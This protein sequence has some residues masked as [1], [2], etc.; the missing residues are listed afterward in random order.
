MQTPALERPATETTVQI[1]A[2]GGAK[3]P[4]PAKISVVLRGD[5]A[6]RTKLALSNLTGERREKTL[7]EYWKS[8]FD[9]IEVKT[10]SAEYD[11]KTGEERLSMEGV[12]TLD[13]QKGYYRVDE[14]V[15]GYH[16]DFS[17]EPGPD[18][19]APIAIAHP[20]YM[21]LSET[22]RLPRGALDK[23]RTK[24]SEVKKTVAGSDYL[25]HVT[26]EDDT[27]KVE[28]SIRSIADE[29]PYSEAQAAQAAMRTL[30]DHVVA[31]WP[32]SNYRA[33]TAD[34]DSALK[35]DPDD[36][37]GLVQRANMLAQS[38]R[39]NEAIKDFDRAKALDP[40]NAQ[41]LA[42]SA[43]THVAAKD[44]AGAEKDLA[45]A[46]AIAPDNLG[47]QGVRGALY[48]ETGRRKE[49]V[50]IYGEV[51]KK[52]PN[53]AAFLAH[54]SEALRKL[55]DLD[56]AVADLDAAIRLAPRTMQYHLTRAA[57]LREQKKDDLAF[58]DAA[59]LIAAGPDN[60]EAYRTAAA[61]YAAG[62]R[63]DDAVKA[64]DR[65]IQLSPTAETY[66]SRSAAR[67]KTDKA[68]R[69]AD[70]DQALKLDPKFASA[71]YS[72]AHLLDETGDTTG[73]IAAYSA[74]L[75]ATPGE[76]TLLVQRAGLYAKTGQ[77]AL[78]EQDLVA[79]RAKAVIP[80]ELNN[81]C[82]MKATSGIALS[83]A[84]KDCDEA[85]KAPPN[86][87]AASTFLDSRGLAL[88]R[89]G[90]LD[91]AITDYTKALEARPDQPT[92]LFGL[93]VAHARKGDLAKA[94]AERAKALRADS[95]V[96]D[97]FKGYGVTFPP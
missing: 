96:A 46:E 82:W 12:A 53:N 6:L 36:V 77:T 5:E 70:L 19:D 51:I 31:I 75:A 35:T 2:T 58:Q 32:A 87:I 13:W 23:N 8:D 24:S 95:K 44:F 93:A 76:T 56:G 73:A 90:R 17:R 25:Q 43:L 54:R 60:M 63:H 34:I 57:I 68:G 22:I 66:G 26:V 97:E 10:T 39:L 81:L 11:P 30:S 69:L 61:I 14:A 88:L 42:M 7:R 20:T 67:A 40:K 78:A 37:A 59:T 84:V 9:F 33:T 62:G 15:I 92:S 94:E 50:V 29:F 72:K 3:A 80:A 55:G 86:P 83:S 41:T 64:M 1:D 45:A 65:V 47:V 91:E 18:R 49:A 71:V 48:E 4:A 85:L 27:F 21:T 52:A 16:A 28:T 89:L 79:A 74:G 38:G